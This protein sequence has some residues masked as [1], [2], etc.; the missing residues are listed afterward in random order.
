MTQ[1]TRMWNPAEMEKNGTKMKKKM[2]IKEEDDARTAECMGPYSAYVKTV[3]QYSRFWTEAYWR[4]RAWQ[5]ESP[6]DRPHLY[7]REY[8]LKRGRYKHLDHMLSIYDGWRKGVDADLIGH[9]RNLRWVSPLTNLRKGRRSIIT[10][11]ELSYMFYQG[12]SLTK[13]RRHLTW[14]DAKQKRICERFETSTKRRFTL[15]DVTYQIHDDQFGSIL[16]YCKSCDDAGIQ[17]P[18]FSEEKKVWN[19]KWHG[20]KSVHNMLCV[21]KVNAQGV[22][23]RHLYK[24][25]LN[26]DEFATI[27]RKLKLV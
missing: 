27:I 14:C 18:L 19:A 17:R 15:N 10:A 1:V 25:F 6:A 20:G 24:L 8:M 4:R 12:V 22:V 21:R 23:S 9:W 2:T 16:H 26:H 7:S 3:K 13:A 5:N 11:N